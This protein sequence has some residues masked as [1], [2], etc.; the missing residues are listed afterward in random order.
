MATME[1]PR[2][3]PRF[4]PVHNTFAF[5]TFNRRFYPKQLYLSIVNHLYVSHH[6]QKAIELEKRRIIYY[7]YYYF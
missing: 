6:K 7:Y 2:F 4:C 5:V 1:V 3:T